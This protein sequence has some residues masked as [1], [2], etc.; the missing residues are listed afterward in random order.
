MLTKEEAQ[1]LTDKEKLTWA[2]QIIDDLISGMAFAEGLLNEAVEEAMQFIC[3]MEG[4][5][6]EQV[7][8]S[9]SGE[10]DPDSVPALARLAARP[11]RP[12]AGASPPGL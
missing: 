2:H 4:I 7:E 8:R 11:P 10:L 6:F 3:V 5:D 12:H 9:C 1:F